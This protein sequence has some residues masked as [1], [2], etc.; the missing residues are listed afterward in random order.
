[1]QPTTTK[2][3]TKK[4][5]E[6]KPEGLKKIKQKNSLWKHFG[7]SKFDVDAVEFQKKLRNEW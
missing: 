3:A 6:I 2:P 1:M 4:A 7:R 5:V